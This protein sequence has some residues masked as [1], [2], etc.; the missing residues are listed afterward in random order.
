LRT[1]AEQV[2]ESH[3]AIGMAPLTRDFLRRYSSLIV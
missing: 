3:N 1:R 2:Y